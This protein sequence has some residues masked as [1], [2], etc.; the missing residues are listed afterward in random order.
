MFKAIAKLVAAYFEPAIR[1]LAD[2]PPQAQRRLLTSW[3]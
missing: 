3:M 2:L 1:T